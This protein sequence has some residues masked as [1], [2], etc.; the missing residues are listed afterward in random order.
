VFV[1]KNIGILQKGLF[2]LLLAFLLFACSR[3]NP[4]NSTAGVSDA[5]DY[6]AVDGLAGDMRIAGSD[7]L[8]SS[9]A[10]LADGFERQQPAVSVQVSGR[11]SGFGFRALLEGDAD[12]AAMSRPLTAQEERAFEQKFG[13]V[14]QAQLL[15]MDAVAV[16]VHPDNPKSAV[17]MDQLKLMFGDADEVPLWGDFGLGGRFGRLAVEA[18]GRNEASGTFA[19]FREVVLGGADYGQG[20]RMLPGSSAVVQHVANAR[21]AIGYVGVGHVSSQV[22]VLPLCVSSGECIAPSRENSLN[23]TYPLARPL[24]VYS[25]LDSGIGQESSNGQEPGESQMEIVR[26]FL[27]YI[28]SREG[29]SIIAADGFFLLPR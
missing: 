18:V 29:Q 24:Y 10:L 11:G 23:G 25:L 13:R 21:T 28:Q 15:A 7:T 9:M 12:I 4:M 1:K 27:R 19:V 26:Q 6:V 3:K 14:P 2:L 22:R 17:T 8:F 16:I 20:Y 5:P